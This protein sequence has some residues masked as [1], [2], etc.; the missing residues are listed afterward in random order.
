MLKI[1]GQGY[2]WRGRRPVLVLAAGA[3]AIAAAAIGGG[4][5][6]AAASAPA[7]SSPGKIVAH[8]ASVIHADG[9]VGGTAVTLGP[10]GYGSA[11]VTCP[12]ATEVFGG[13]ESNNAP[14]VLVLT[15]SWPNSNTSWL[16]YV[17]NNSTGTYQFTPY[18]ICR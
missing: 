14:G 16:V 5:A 18:A 13:G 2:S 7:G 8:P 15:D 4:V 9:M 11:V 6:I 1:A 10:N 12:A 17:K 3:A